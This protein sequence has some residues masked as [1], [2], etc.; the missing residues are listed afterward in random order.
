L[1][2][3]TMRETVLLVVLKQAYDGYS[4]YGTIPCG[5]SLGQLPLGKDSVSVSQ[6]DGRSVYVSRMEFVSAL[7]RKSTVIELPCCGLP[8]CDMSCGKYSL[9]TDVASV[10]P[11]FAHGVK[12]ARTEMIQKL[13][14]MATWS[15]N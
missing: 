14:S 3:L 15:N 5:M 2:T 1:L 11:N 7:L 4:C 8:P 9:N 10:N 13:C 6:S 12:E